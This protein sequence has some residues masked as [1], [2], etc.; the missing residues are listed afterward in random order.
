MVRSITYSKRQ[1]APTKYFPSTGTSVLTHKTTCSPLTF[2]SGHIG[3][4]LTSS[5][6][7]SLSNPLGTQ[8]PLSQWGSLGV[9]GKVP[10]E[11]EEL[12]GHT[13]RRT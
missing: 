7:A 13:L 2:C 1:E 5:D 4:Q 12:G 8:V 6:L 10:G 11:R 3:A 9:E